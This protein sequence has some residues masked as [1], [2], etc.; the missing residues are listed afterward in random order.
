VDPTTIML[1]LAAAGAGLWMF[2][3]RD[4]KFPIEERLPVIKNA[5]ESG[6][7]LRL[8]CF[9]NSSKRFSWR[10]VTP[11][12]IRYEYQSVYLRAFDHWRKDERTF[13]VSRI[14]TIQQV[15]RERR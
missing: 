9:A 13:K 12:E 2:S 5:I 3:R 7:D 11:I 10:T 8:E 6:E 15:L 4:R 1:L 14:K